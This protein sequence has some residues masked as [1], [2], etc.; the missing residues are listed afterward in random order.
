MKDNQEIGRVTLSHGLAEREHGQSVS[1]TR[2]RYVSKHEK[3]E[4][5][6][7]THQGRAATH[8]RS[9]SSKEHK[10][11][12]G[13]HLWTIQR[14]HWTFGVHSQTSNDAAMLRPVRM[15][16]NLETQGTV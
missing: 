3:S 16:Y 1:N 11:K 15:R 8:R 7:G 10:G 2:R 13:F 9:G 6:P 5:R 4:D 14:Q 12:K